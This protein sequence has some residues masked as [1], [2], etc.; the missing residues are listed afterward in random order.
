[1]TD[2]AVFERRAGKKVPLGSLGGEPVT[3][4]FACGIVNPMG[5]TLNALLVQG[6]PT[7]DV[8]LPVLTHQPA[9]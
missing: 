6:D 2:R 5:P 9:T 4:L 1:M 3:A 7:R 8:A